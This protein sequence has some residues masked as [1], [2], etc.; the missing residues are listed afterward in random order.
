MF[1]KIS[2]IVLFIVTLFSIIFGIKYIRNQRYPGFELIKAVPIDAVFVTEINGTIGKLGLLQKENEIWNELK[3]FSLFNQFDSDIT[4][5]TAWVIKNPQVSN[6]LNQNKVLISAHKINNSSIDFIYYLNLNNVRDKKQI[7][8]SVTQQIPVG[9][10]ITQRKFGNTI[11]YSIVSNTQKG[12]KIHFSFYKGIVIA[13]ASEKMIEN[14]IN[15]SDTSE[16]LMNDAGYLRVS[17][18]AGKNVD[19]ALYLNLKHMPE[20]ISL[21]VNKEYK[22]QIADFTNL[23]NWAEL[24]LS[25]K[26]HPHFCLQFSKHANTRHHS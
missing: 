7:I 14:A 2:I 25:I 9:E 18:T 1:K 5:F 6:L 17:K 23:G 13:S 15:Q 11:I 8:E 24:D 20:A 19:A 4:L 12:K 10:K 26:Q 22:K 3:Q 16:S 21:L